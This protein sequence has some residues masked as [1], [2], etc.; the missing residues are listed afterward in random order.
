MNNWNPRPI[1]QSYSAYTPTLTQINKMHLLNKNAPDNIMLRLETIDG[2][3]P[4]LDDG[5]S[6]S[7]FLTHYQPTLLENNIL[8]LHRKSSATEVQKLISIKEGSFLLGEEIQLPD[9]STPLFAQIFIKE[10][11]LGKLMNVLYKPT[12]L[13]I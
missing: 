4:S 12:Q 1:L 13:L 2:R 5:A 3:M 10:T 7:I 11:L 6:W 9:S 8:Y